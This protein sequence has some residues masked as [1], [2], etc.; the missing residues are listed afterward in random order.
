MFSRFCVFLLLIVS[1]S[2]HAAP[3]PWEGYELTSKTAPGY[4]PDRDTDEGGLWMVSNKVEEATI[5]SPFLVRSEELNHYVRDIV[6]RLAGEYCSD[7]RVYILRNPNFNA[8]MYPNGMMHIWT[9]LLLRVRNEAQLATVLGHEIAHYL[10]KHSIQNWKSVKSKA[11]AATLVSMVS[12]GAGV[13]YVG[14]IFAL[15][16]LANIMSYSRAKEREADAYGLRLIAQAG[17]SPY[18]AAEVW[19][20]IIREN[21]SAKHKRTSNVF[22]QSHPSPKGRTKELDRLARALP[23]DRSFAVHRDLYLSKLA[24]H[25]PELLE[26][27]LKQR[28]HDRTQA[29]LMELED[30]DVGSIALDYYWARFYRTRMQEGDVELATEHYNKAIGAGRAPPEAFRDLGYIALKK[31]E[32][33][34]AKKNFSLYLEQKPEASDRAM[35]EFYLSM[36]N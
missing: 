4:A 21:N 33:K 32:L 15:G 19:N 28:Q 26:E 12:S 34:I 29:L 17:Y 22:T 27:E 8:S 18:E 6:C 2:S 31:K 16:M 14:D 3:N 35:I 5:N 1:G 13:G 20:Y 7:I 11:T 25:Y 36:D 24:S 9:G 30:A 10:R 23:S